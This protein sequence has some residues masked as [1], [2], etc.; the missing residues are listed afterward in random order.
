M[1]DRS[2]KEL[3]KIAS[4]KSRPQFTK[5]KDEGFSSKEKKN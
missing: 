2:L 3:Q 5:T 1:K 4:F